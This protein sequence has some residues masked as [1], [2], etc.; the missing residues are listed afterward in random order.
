[1]IRGATLAAPSQPQ[2]HGVLAAMVASSVEAAMVMG[3][4]HPEVA[5]HVPQKQVP[6]GKKPRS[7]K[8]IRDACQ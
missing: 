8:I 7:N 6:G 4:T 5:S 2:N 1:M 3:I